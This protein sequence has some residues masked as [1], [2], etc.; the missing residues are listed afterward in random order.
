MLRARGEAVLVVVVSLTSA[1]SDRPGKG[2]FQVRSRGSRRLVL[3]TD[4]GAFTI[5]GVRVGLAL[6][7]DV[8]C[9]GDLAKGDGGRARGPR[10]ISMGGALPVDSGP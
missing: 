10:S 5:E 7:G 4:F 6:T 3:R 2:R 9:A 8:N 1:V